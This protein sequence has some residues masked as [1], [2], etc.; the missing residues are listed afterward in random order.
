[1]RFVAFF[2]TVVVA[3]AL[4]SV[5]IPR[6]AAQIPEG[7]E[8]VEIF[9]AGTEYYCGPPDINDRGQI[10]FH[11]RLWPT[12]DQIEIMLYDRRKLIQPTDDD[13]YDSF[14]RINN[15]GVIVW[16]RDLDPDP[17]V[18]RIGIVRWLGGQMAVISDP[19]D[20]YLGEGPAD[21]NDAGQ[22]VWNR[23]LRERPDEPQLFLFD[24]SSIRPVTDDAFSNQSVRINQNSEFVWTQ[25]DF[26]VSPWVSQVFVF[27]GGP[28]T[29][30]TNGQRQVQNPDIN[31]FRE[32]VWR[33]PFDGVQVWRMG[34]T[35]TVLGENSGVGGINNRGWITIARK[36]PASGNSTL[37]LYRHGALTRLTEPSLRAGVGRINT[38]G[39]IAFVMGRLPNI[40]VSIF[41]KE[42]FVADLDLDADV[43]LNDVAVFQRCF[44]TFPSV[45]DECCSSSDTNCDEAVDRCDFAVLFRFLEGARRRPLGSVR[46]LARSS[47]ITMRG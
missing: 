9:P 37:W 30:L 34:T 14:P 35:T 6:A 31:D 28:L 42:S 22:I 8:I 16:S 15:H 26:S 19:G 20:K 33:S 18:E 4:A 10:V 11:R 38:R 36:D 41:T 24:G 27:F 3:L 1:M 47:A 5:P 13:V 7:W 17:S 45:Y 44:G 39:E 29:R 25:Y 46:L 43:D 32:V 12:R 2:V 40:G 23:S 21:I